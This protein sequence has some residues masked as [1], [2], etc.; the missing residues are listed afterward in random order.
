MGGTKGVID[1]YVAETG[2]RF[3]ECLDG[4]LVRFHLQSQ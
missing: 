2:E 1:E 4:R 3:A